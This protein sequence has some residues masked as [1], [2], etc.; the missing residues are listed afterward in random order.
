MERVNSL[1]ASQ[2]STNIFSIRYAAPPIGSLRWKAP[3]TPATNRTITLA[4]TFGSICPQAL[5][6]VPNAPFIPGNEDCLF[7]NVYKPTAA[8]ASSLPVLVWIHGG[9]YGAGDATQDMTE[10]INANNNGF[11]AV[12]IQYRVR[13]PP[14]SSPNLRHFSKALFRRAD[15]QRSLAHLVF[16]RRAK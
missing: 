12:S 9:G 6:A 13:K 7:L 5:P 4:S 11:V 8:V 15:I 16:S 2:T 10:I 1:C 14:I 3:Q